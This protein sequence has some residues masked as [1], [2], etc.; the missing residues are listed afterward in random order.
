MAGPHATMSRLQLVYK[1]NLASGERDRRA[2]PERGVRR[3]G[4]HVKV[5]RQA[6]EVL[7]LRRQPRRREDLRA[8]CQLER[9][10]VQRDSNTVWTSASRK[11]TAREDRVILR[12]LHRRQPRFIVRPRP[13]GPRVEQNARLPRARRRHDPLQA[14]RAA[15]FSLEHVER[16]APR[17]SEVVRPVVEAA[18]DG[19]DA[20][21]PVCEPSR[22][23]AGL[24]IRG[25]AVTRLV[26]HTGRDSPKPTSAIAEL[27]SGKR[28]WT[29]M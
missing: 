9:V 22:P 2:G 24:I 5:R 21:R 25:G 8:V 3:V 10:A 28:T 23:Q 26:V 1:I 11:G 19:G 17:D 29:I 12:V 20:W 15:R 7:F 14:R 6:R 16:A 4:G 13:R 18:R 27:P